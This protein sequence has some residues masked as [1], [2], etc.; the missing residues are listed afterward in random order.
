[1][2]IHIV[3]IR[4]TRNNDERGKLSD[5]LAQLELEVLVFIFEVEQPAKSDSELVFIK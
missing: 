5:K 2:R 1:M 3:H 4:N